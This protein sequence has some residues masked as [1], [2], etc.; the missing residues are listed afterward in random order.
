MYYGLKTRAMTKGT[1][2]TIFGVVG[3]ILAL[4]TIYGIIKEVI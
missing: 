4:I 1:I 3:I 2:L